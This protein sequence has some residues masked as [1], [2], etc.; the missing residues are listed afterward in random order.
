M[1]NQKKEKAI[2]ISRYNEMLDWMSMID[3]SWDV[4]IYNKGSP[5]FFPAYKHLP[6]IG[7]E[8]HTYLSYILEF[9]DNLPPHNVFLQGDAFPVHVPNLEYELNHLP[10]INYQ[11][12]GNCH[13]AVRGV[14]PP[15]HMTAYY[16]CNISP[17][18]LYEEYLGQDANKVE[19]INYTFYACACFYVHKNNILRHPR[20]VYQKLLDVYNNYKKF[21]FP[22]LEY[23]WHLIFDDVFY[24]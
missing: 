23:S 8:G 5:D 15:P 11:G 14:Y 24:P 13:F 20:Q 9:Y 18:Q 1:K 17:K 6:N 16:N 4:Y 21:P 10:Y 7:R 2:I 22:P 19:H 12:M 3:M